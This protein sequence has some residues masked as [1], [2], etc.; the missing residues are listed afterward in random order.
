MPDL[1]VDRVDSFAL[2]HS[3]NA[4]GVLITQP[5]YQ[6]SV[7]SVQMSGEVPETG[8]PAEASVDEHIKAINSEQ[9]RVSLTSWEDIQSRMTEPDVADHIRRWQSLLDGLWLEK[10][11]QIG[12]EVCKSFGI[13]HHSDGVDFKFAEFCKGL[14]LDLVLK[15]DP[16]NY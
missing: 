12:N 9:S 4:L 15:H 1:R 5:S 8:L 10:R 14:V 3:I 6:D 2:Q 11:F 13:F 16:I 7:Q